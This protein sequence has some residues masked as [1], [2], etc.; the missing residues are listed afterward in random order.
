MGLMDTVL[1]VA[2]VNRGFLLFLRFAIG[3]FVVAPTIDECDGSRRLSVFVVVVV[4]FFGDGTN[5]L[6]ESC[7]Y[8]VINT[9]TYQIRSNK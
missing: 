1:L 2:V 3:F 5:S 6:S 8:F 9:C 4:F 7:T